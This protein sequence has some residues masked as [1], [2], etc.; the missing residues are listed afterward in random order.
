[1]I[2]V[3]ASWLDLVFAKPAFSDRRRI[4]GDA[5]QLSNG[6]Q[7][8]GSTSFALSALPLARR[9]GAAGQPSAPTL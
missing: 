4:L 3:F 7:S 9:Q 6:L 5:S 1:L 8:R 2:I